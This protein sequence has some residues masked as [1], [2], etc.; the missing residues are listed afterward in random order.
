[1]KTKL[2]RH[3]VLARLIAQGAFQTQRELLHALEGEGILIRQGTLAKD[4]EALKVTKVRIPADGPPRYNL[5]RQYEVEMPDDLIEREIRDFVRTVEEATNLVVV[6][7]SSG[8]ASGVCETIDQ[9]GWPELV[10]S[11]A[12]ENTILLVCKTNE[13]AHQIVTRFHRILKGKE[14]P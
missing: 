11:I 9:I 7:T 8:H 10:G 5:P 1:M 14:G 12:G 6:K 2:N 13:Q 4:L 3:Q